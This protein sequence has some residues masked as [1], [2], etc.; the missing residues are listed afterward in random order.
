[1]PDYQKGKIYK[2]W[3][4]SNNLTY[5]GSTVQSLAQ[6]LAKHQYNYKCFVN[7]DTKSSK[8]S[9]LIIKYEDYKIELVENYPCNNVEQLRRREGEYIQSNECVNY[10]VAGRTKEEYREETKEAHRE[11]TKI[12]NQ[13]HREKIKERKRVYYQEHKEK[14]NKRHSAEDS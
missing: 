7:G 2:I 10:Q 5:Y 8:K 9:F 14:W 3:S 11:Y 1:M 6:R 13:E 12:Y 4:P